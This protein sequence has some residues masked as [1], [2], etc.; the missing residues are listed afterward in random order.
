MY[1]NHTKKALCAYQITK[2]IV[3]AKCPDCGVFGKMTRYTMKL[4]VQNKGLLPSDLYATG[5]FM[6]IID[7]AKYYNGKPIL[8][9]THS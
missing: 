9:T 4:D 7:A 6:A 2:K 8:A 5:S 1:E 3:S